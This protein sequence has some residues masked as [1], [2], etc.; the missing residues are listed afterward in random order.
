VNGLREAGCGTAPCAL[1]DARQRNAHRRGLL[2]ANY[3]AMQ[4]MPQVGIGKLGVL[5]ASVDL[6]AH[7]DITL[8]DLDDVDARTQLA[9]EGQWFG[10]LD[11]EFRGVLNQGLGCESAHA[12]GKA[13]HPN[14]AKSLKQ[15]TVW[16]RFVCS[17]GAVLYAHS[18]ESPPFRGQCLQAPAQRR[19]QE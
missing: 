7:V 8:A 16:I 4:P 2:E 12:G 19:N 15:A 3:S 9:D 11:V 13:E 14:N 5:V 17:R 10:A 1:V 6:D 18:G